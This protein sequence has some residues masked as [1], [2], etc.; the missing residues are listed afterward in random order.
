MS[1]NQHTTSIIHEFEVYLRDVRR[2]STHTVRNYISDLTQFQEFLETQGWIEGHLT[3]DQL[4][5]ITLDRLRSFMSNAYQK[6]LSTPTMSRRISALKSLFE[7]LEKNKRVSVNPMTML[8]SV[9]V[10]KNLPNVPSEEDVAKLLD[11]QKEME[12]SPRDQALFELMYGCGLRV[13]EVVKMD[14]SDIGVEQLQLHV[15]DSKR[16]KSR[17]VPFSEG[18][19]EVL[20]KYRSEF[21][22]LV[23]ETPVFLNAKGKRITTRG[24]QYILEK[25]LQKFPKSM[26]LTPHSFRHGY[27]THLLNRGADLRSIQELLGHSNLSTTERYTK[28]GLTHL[29][30]VFARSHPR[31]KS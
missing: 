19:A 4:S 11:F 9:K 23:P 24:V 1:K 26:H 22:V 20:K 31:S 21:K 16:G 30:E 6:K 27:A 10:R 2:V 25:L 8:E 17:I 3:Q 5:T 12:A 18:L 15:R 7:W 29:K 13:S 28:V 14:W